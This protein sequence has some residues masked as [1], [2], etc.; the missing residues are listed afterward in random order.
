[1]MGQWDS[2]AV[3]W[4]SWLRCGLQTEALTYQ[5]TVLTQHNQGSEQFC[6]FSTSLSI[7][8]KMILWTAKNSMQISYVAS[9]ERIPNAG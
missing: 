9:V 5:D 2:P 4:Y 8:K 3:E 7:S 6:Q 1:M